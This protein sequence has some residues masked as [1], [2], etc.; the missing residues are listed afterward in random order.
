MKKIL[1]ILPILLIISWCNLQ[2]SWNNKETT[3]DI[4]QEL[5]CL[6]WEYAKNT[7]KSRSNNIVNNYYKKTWE[8]KNN[9]W[10]PY[11]EDIKEIFYSPVKNKCYY[12]AHW[13][14]LVAGSDISLILIDVKNSEEVLN[15]YDILYSDLN[16]CENINWYRMDWYGKEEKKLNCNIF[17]NTIKKLKTK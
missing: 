14:S 2:Q 11:K 5:I 15:F 10:P 7:A 9:Q 1:F 4:D 13:E 17:L 6:K 8:E 12:I 16:S 3:S